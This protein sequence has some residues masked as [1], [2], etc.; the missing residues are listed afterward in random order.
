[1]LFYI[2]DQS[3]SPS[4]C[5]SSFTEFQNRTIKLK[6]SD[7]WAI[8]NSDSLVTV[9]CSLPNYLIPKYEI[10][11]KPSLHFTLRVFGWMLT[12][13]HEICGLAV[14]HRSRERKRVRASLGHQC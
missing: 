8:Y 13:E 12:E 11:V 7:S 1:M 5:Y 3:Q 4:V 9:T 6:V 10:F 2:E 14:R